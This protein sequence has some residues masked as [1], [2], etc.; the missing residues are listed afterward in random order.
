MNCEKILIVGLAIVA[1]IFAVACYEPISNTSGG[2]D[3]SPKRDVPESNVSASSIENKEE[4]VNKTEKV[5]LNT[6]IKLKVAGEKASR[7]KIEGFRGSLSDNLSRS[8]LSVSDIYDSTNSVENRILKEYGSVFLT[9]AMPPTKAMFTSEQEVSAFQSKAGSASANVN[10]S[11]VELQPAAL[12][13]L[14]SAIADAKSA[15][16]KITPRDKK[17]NTDSAKRTYQQTLDLWN[18]RFYKACDHWK[19][20]KRLTDQQISNLKSLP[21]KQQ[22][23]EVLELEKKGI[24]FSTFFN[25]SIL[26]SVAA[27]G[28][29][30]H[31]SMLAFDAAEFQNKKVRAILAKHGWF[32]TVQNDEPHFTYLGYNENELPGIGLKKV[33]RKNGEFW[34]PNL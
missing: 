32:R 9:K 19:G 27:P 12:K 22:V 11:N 2:S 10:G 16:L 20:K 6:D 15:G 7:I 18:G 33:I 24:Y 28:T 23:Q 30:Q 8:G 4:K 26:F 31:L 21:I 17:A 14:E 1:S 3:S 13:A 29:S 5:K 34:I 25:Q